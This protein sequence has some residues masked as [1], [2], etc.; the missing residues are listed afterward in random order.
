MTFTKVLFLC[1][2]IIIHT[3][4]LVNSSTDVA[5]NNGVSDARV[6]YA[7]QKIR[8][9]ES[10]IVRYRLRPTVVLVCSVCTN[11][12]INAITEVEAATYPI[13]ELSISSY[14]GLGFKFGRKLNKCRFV[15]GL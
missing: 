14:L 4:T 13:I 12:E 2:K 11:W 3:P 6:A 1:F 7:T 5:N 8:L 10:N 9:N 15:G